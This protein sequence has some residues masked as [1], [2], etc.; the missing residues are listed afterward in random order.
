MIPLSERIKALLDYSGLSIIDFSRHLGL[1]SPNAIREIIK[2]RTKTLSDAVGIRIT[3]TYPNINHEWLHKGV[4]DMFKPQQGRHV[5]D[6][7]NG[8]VVT[9]GDSSP[10]LK[11]VNIQLDDQLAISPEMPKDFESCKSEVIKLH[12][13][14]SQAEKE[15][16]RLE[17]KVEEQDKFIS[18]LLN[19]K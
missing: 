13:L 10:V 18:L 3:F 16:A 4:G 5:N 19:R 17:G 8:S 15:I 7:S 1:N 9:M 2:G 11:D 14:L 6:V 12:K